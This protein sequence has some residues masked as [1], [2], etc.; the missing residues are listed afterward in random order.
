MVKKQIALLM[1][2]II[3]CT[4][5][6]SCT[7]IPGLNNSDK[8]SSIIPIPGISKSDEALIEE[9]ITDF[10]TA[11]NDGDMDTVLTCLDTKS[12]NAFKSMLNIL[13]GLAGKY[14]GFD[15]NLS[16]L[17]SLGVNTASGN[18]MDLEISDISI[19]DNENAVVTTTMKLA[20]AGTQTIYFVMVYEKGGWYISDMTDKKPTILVGNSNQSG[21]NVNVTD[22]GIVNNGTARVDFIIGDKT[23]SGIINSKG[24]IFYYCEESYINWTSVGDGA[25]YITTYVDD[26]K[27]YTLFNSDNQKTVTVDG[28]IFDKIIGYGDGLLLVYKNTSTISTIEHS[29]GVLDC[30]GNW[31]K[32]LTPGTMLPIPDAWGWDN[33]KYI[34]EDVF[35]SHNY[36][37]YTDHYIMYNSNINKAFFLEDCVIKN[38]KFVNGVL[39]GVNTGWGLSCGEISDYSSGDN[40]SELPGYFALHTDGTFEEVPRFTNASG[41]LLINVN[42]SAVSSHN[43]GEYMTVLDLKNNNVYEYKDF[44][45]YMIGSVKFDGNN[46]LIILKGADGNRYFTLIDEKCNQK[47]EPTVCQ[48]A[49]ISCDRIVYKNAND[50]YEVIDLNGNVIV[51]ENQGYTSIYSFD[52]GIALAEN[53]GG[54]CYIDVNGNKLTIKLLG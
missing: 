21:T 27:V 50:F 38:S 47:I 35:I 25:G 32:S 4:A 8:I 46:G 13:G 29:Y 51:S 9:R 20:G 42:N 5:F 53:E 34:G 10:Y 1:T 31:V 17:F 39:Y 14:A 54:E 22:L 44:S 36:Y 33:F 19:V 43:D 11:Y 26:E 7:S 23:Y 45:A 15:I 6:S 16:D 18:F 52:T 41:N 37:G 48:D 49:N 24:E 28:D 2:F 30:D 12:R 3:I 40:N